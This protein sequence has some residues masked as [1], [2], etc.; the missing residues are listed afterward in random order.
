M[1]ELAKVEI[2]SDP[3]A[4]VVKWV[5]TGMSEAEILEALKANWPEEDGKPLILQSLKKIA[6]SANPDG[7]LIL[8][9]AIEGTR[10]VYQ[11]AMEAGDNNAALRALK[12]L[13][14][15]AHP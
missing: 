13:V 9:F 15:L 3:L 7:D 14:D 4:Q 1:G 12:Q 6:K 10:A 2:P 5:V 11:K 8:G